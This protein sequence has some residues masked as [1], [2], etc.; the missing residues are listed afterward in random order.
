MLTGQKIRILRGCKTTLMVMALKEHPTAIE[1]T[2]KRAFD[3]VDGIP[4]GLAGFDA[5]V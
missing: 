1:G 4:C 5:A 2:A 3:I